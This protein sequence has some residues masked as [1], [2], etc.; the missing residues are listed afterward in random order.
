MVETASECCR[1][2]EEDEYWP[3]DNLPC[4]PHLRPHTI[5]IGATNLLHDVDFCI[6]HGRKQLGLPIVPISSQ[7]LQRRYIC[8]TVK[9]TCNECVCTTI[10]SPSVHYQIQDPSRPS[11]RSA[12]AKLR[13]ALIKLSFNAKKLFG[14]KS[15]GIIHPFSIFHLALYTFLTCSRQMSR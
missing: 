3:M 15:E 5:G 4:Q 13:L 9:K 12:E 6:Q 1:P 8:Y 14:L 2:R 7:P 11:K 10:A